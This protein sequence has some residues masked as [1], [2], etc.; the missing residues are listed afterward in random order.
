MATTECTEIDAQLLA[1]LKQEEALQW[2]K[3]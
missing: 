1:A 2:N 3:A